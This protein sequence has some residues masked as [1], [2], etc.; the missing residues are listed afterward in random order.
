MRT[1][2]SKLYLLSVILLFIYAPLQAQILDDEAIGDRPPRQMFDER[3]LYS[4]FIFFDYL[5]DAK[6]WFYYFD[7]IHRRQSGLEN[8][9]LIEQP[10]RTSIR[11]YIAYQFGRFTRVHFSPV[12]LFISDPRQGQPNDVQQ[13]GDSEYELRSTLEITQDAYIKKAGKEWINMTHRW[14]FE[15]RWRGVDEPMGPVWNYRMRQ[16]TRFRIPINGKHFYD[17]NV[18]Y[19]VNYHELHI[20]FGPNM[21][22]NHFAQSRN[23]VGL[24][25]RFWD[26][27]RVDVGY[28]HQYN[29]RGDGRTIDM[30]RGPM[31]YFF[32]D[33]FSKLRIGRDRL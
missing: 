28:L 1:T 9:N 23:F 29:F 33:Y 5:S 22:L 32:I 16:R 8:N 27:A 25:Y 15:S 11:P 24:G 30:S 7:I 26:W 3:V 17:N 10:L 21:N 12:A 2:K 13:I 19:T 31:V 14:R 20:E 6:T 4:K 18:I